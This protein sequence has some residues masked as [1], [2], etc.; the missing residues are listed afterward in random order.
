MNLYEVLFSSK[1]HW[2]LDENF[3]YGDDR[4]TV[5]LQWEIFAY[6]QI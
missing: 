1:T 6:V 4:T 2:I 3:Y 5:L